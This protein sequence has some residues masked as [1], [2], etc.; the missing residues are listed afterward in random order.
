MLFRRLSDGH[1][2]T[3]SEKYT[4]HSVYTITY[5][6]YND[7]NDILRGTR[8]ISLVSIRFRLLDEKRK[9]KIF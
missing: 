7:D 6:A 5:C 9:K 2:L 1:V 8:N 4:L 3:A